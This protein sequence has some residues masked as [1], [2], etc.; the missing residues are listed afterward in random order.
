[1]SLHLQ[2]ESRIVGSIFV[3]AVLSQI[4]GWF[5]GLVYITGSFPTASLKIESAI[6]IFILFSSLFILAI[7]IKRLYLLAIILVGALMFY[8]LLGIV[9]NIGINS[10]MDVKGFWI[11]I[12]LV[13][14]TLLAWMVISAF[15][16]K[17]ISWR[18]LFFSL[19]GSYLGVIYLGLI[20]L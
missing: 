18:E 5:P 19:A 9:N 20:R 6:V 10:P 7:E 13:V 3:S 17:I 1:M 16:K 14:V 12:N 15:R 4:F 11:T 2:K 8:G